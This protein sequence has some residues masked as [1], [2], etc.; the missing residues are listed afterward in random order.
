MGHHIGK[1]CFSRDFGG[2]FIDRVFGKRGS[3]LIFLR[4][5]SCSEARNTFCQTPKNTFTHPEY[6]SRIIG[7]FLKNRQ[8]SSP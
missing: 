6:N 7:T 1:Q 4:L 5:K 8:K 2:L 3:D